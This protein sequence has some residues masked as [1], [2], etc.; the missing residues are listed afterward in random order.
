ML[1]VIKKDTESLSKV[2]YDCTVRKLAHLL[3]DS[4]QHRLMQGKENLRECEHHE[5]VVLY[6]QVDPTSSD[7]S[8]T[9][10]NVL[11]EKF[12]ANHAVYFF[13]KEQLTSIASMFLRSYQ[14]RLVRPCK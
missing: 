10:W 11:I 12:F 1:I 2:D 9:Q 14:A 4:F 6:C 5:F 3:G 8:G 13:N 7:V